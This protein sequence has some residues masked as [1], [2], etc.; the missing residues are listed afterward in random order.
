MKAESKDK[1]IKD[2]ID[3]KTQKRVF[4]EVS[5]KDIV[6]GKEIFYKRI[7]VEYEFKNLD[8]LRRIATINKMRYRKDKRENE[9]Y[10]EGNGYG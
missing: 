1:L 4:I 5:E 10:K 9:N 8:E 3:Q 6:L 2:T 7:E